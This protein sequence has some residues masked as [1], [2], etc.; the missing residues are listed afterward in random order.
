[1]Y[2]FKWVTIL[3]L[4]LFILPALLFAAAQ[5]NHLPFTFKEIPLK[6][7]VKKD[8]VM[9]EAFKGLP[10]KATRKISF[11]SK[12]GSWMSLDISPDGQTL[13]FDLMG[14]LYSMPVTGGKAIALTK[15][16]AY[17]VHPRYSPD[18]KNVLIPGKKFTYLVFKQKP[19][20]IAKVMEDLMMHKPV[21]R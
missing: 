6:D 1:M 11:N 3:K 5:L 7:T 4:L 10:L 17:D 20:A 13:L 16:L 18:G 12:E 15:G 14:D 21:K 8:T 9:Y 19:E 2:I